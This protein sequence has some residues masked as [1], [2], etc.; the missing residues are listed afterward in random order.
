M[1]GTELLRDG[2][3]VFRFGKFGFAKNNR[4]RAWSYT[5]PAQNADQCAGVDASG[6]ENAKGHVAD[7]LGADRLFQHR[8]NAR[9]GGFLI[10]EKGHSLAS[11]RPII[12]QV[13]IARHSQC[14]VYPRPAV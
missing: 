3:G 10:R 4:E 11:I 13:P 5:S 6:K 2:T 14:T 9:A 12:Y 1:I 8:L 7:Q